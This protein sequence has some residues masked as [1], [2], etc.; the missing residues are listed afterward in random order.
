MTFEIILEQLSSNISKLLDGMKI[1]VAY[2]VEP[3]KEGFG[4]VVCNVAFLLAKE[5]KKSPK[6]IAIML[7]KEYEAKFKDE[8]YNVV[9]H[10]SGYLN[11]IINMEKFTSKTLKK[12][13]KDDYGNGGEGGI[14]TVEHTSVNPNKAIHIGHVRNMIIGDVVSR[15]LLKAGN[16]V[17]VLNYIDDSGLQ[18]ADII[19]GFK[20]LKFSQDSKDEKFDH[21]C[22]DVVYVNTTKQYETKPELKVKRN[23]I[24]EEMDDA[25][26]DTAKFASKITRKILKQQIKTCWRLGVTYDCLNF[27]SQIIQ[28]GMW[29]EIFERLKTDGTIIQE[30]EGVNAGCWIHKD[31]NYDKIV[32]RSNGVATYF[33][34]DIP[35]AIWKMGLIADPFKYVQYSTQY[36]DRVL[37]QT[38]LGDEGE[39]RDFT[40]QQII[41]IIDNR[42]SQLQDMITKLMSK[43]NNTITYTHLGYEAVTLSSTTAKQLGLDTS[44]KQVQMSG[45]KGIYINADTV[46]DNLYTKTLQE[47][48]KRNP[49]LKESLA[50]DI[51]NDLAIGALRYEMIKQDLDRKIVFD[52][53]ESLN[54]HGDTAAYIQYAYTRANRILEK[55]KNKSNDSSLNNLID[56]HERLLIIEIS[57]FKMHVSDAARNL[58]PKIIAKYCHTLAVVFNSFY[59]Q[60]RIIDGKDQSVQVSRLYLVES[61]QKTLLSALYL[62]G[63]PVPDR[64]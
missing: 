63:I 32:V 59:E 22:G 36:N 51:A 44:N 4:D 54:L 35:Y 15:I 34:K 12:S 60:V 55:S 53:D 13:M 11:F 38:V 18:I 52:L 58:S 57:K 27:E 9:S 56:K 1:K 25:K 31:E 24:L 26:S 19:L 5:M 17:H 21:Y 50:Q 29:S 62:L 37:W 64:M 46:L 20:E 33:A 14:I 30:K 43:I 2:T 6:D 61:F 3:A 40:G 10:P 45:R 42:Q 48:Q 16:K 28:S 7:A 49:D 8:A 23:K 39:K 47:T 41:T